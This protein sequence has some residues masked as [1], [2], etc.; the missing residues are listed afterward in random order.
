MLQSYKTQ[1]NK[2][3]NKH[4]DYLQDIQNNEMWL[5]TGIQQWK[6]IHVNARFQH[7]LQQVVALTQ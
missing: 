7:T 4:G 1:N 5:K 6:W 2:G 3:E